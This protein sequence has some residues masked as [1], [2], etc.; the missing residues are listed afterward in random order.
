MRGDPIFARYCASLETLH[1][2]KVE[3]QSLAQNALQ[4]LLRHVGK[5]I[6][7]G[8]GS[9]GAAAW[10][11]T[12]VEPDLVAGAIAL[13]PPGPPFGTACPKERNPYREYT[14]FIQYEEG[15]RIYGLTDIPLTYDPPAHP[16]GGYDHPEKNPLDITEHTSVDGNSE[17]LLQCKRA[18][19][20][21]NIKKVP[22]AVVTAHA[23]SHGMYDWATVAFMVQ[24]GV[25][26]E[27]IKLQDKNILGNGHLMFLETNSNEIAQ[28]L[29]DWILENAI[30]APFQMLV[31]EP[32]PPPE[33]S[34]FADTVERLGPQREPSVE[35]ISSQKTQLLDSKPMDQEMS[36]VQLPE[37]PQPSGEQETR[38][39]QSES[40]GGHSIGNS[41]KRAALSS[42]QTTISI[43][44]GTD[45]PYLPSTSVGNPKRRRVILATGMSTPSSASSAISSSQERSDQ[46]QPKEVA[47][48]PEQQIQTTAAEKPVYD[49]SLLKP[50]LPGEVPS[51]LKLP[52]NKGNQPSMAS[53][54]LSIPSQLQASRLFNGRASTL[55]EHLPIAQQINALQ[56][57]Y[58]LSFTPNKGHTTA[59][60]ECQTGSAEEIAATMYNQ[61]RLPSGLAYPGTIPGP[62]FGPWSPIPQVQQQGSY[63]QRL[64]H[65]PA[66]SGRGGLMPVPTSTPTGDQFTTATLAGPY[67]PLMPPS[68]LGG[69]SYN[70]FGTYPQMTPPSPSPAPRPSSNPP[71][72]NLSMGSPAAP[73][74]PKTPASK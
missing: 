64:D 23:S 25:K 2:N 40:S 10:L 49:I 68:T 70:P 66:L 61:N 17:C 39:H 5:S 8:E 22:N 67:T 60:F 44:N 31:S 7:V 18:R 30:P 3:R 47:Q 58:Q 46:T 13:E 74:R 15:T 69:H 53:P 57:D 56:R 12:D 21:I 35:S 11:A 29:M 41:N 4:A 32:T 16:H 72:L 14:P 63:P 54:A 33:F 26:C 27:L 37:T 19:R 59:R 48:V 36:L 20:L 73:A 65:S 52:A 1:L 24:A 28:V 50:T 43:A 34:E 71:A 6:L 45:S 55:Y 51:Y 42:G 9:G 38:P 62:K